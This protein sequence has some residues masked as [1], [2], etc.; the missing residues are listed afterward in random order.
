MCPFISLAIFIS[1]KIL[2]TYFLN[3]CFPY[4]FIFTINFD[5]RRGSGLL[6]WKLIILQL[7]SIFLYNSILKIYLF[8]IIGVRVDIAYVNTGAGGILKGNQMPWSWSDKQLWASWH[9]LWSKLR[10]CARTACAPNCSTTS[11]E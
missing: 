1:L 7:I 6:S 4:D 8:I 3:F 10:S 5:W 2:V 9:L 11:L